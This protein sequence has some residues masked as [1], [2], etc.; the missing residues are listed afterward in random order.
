M[1]KLFTT[2]LG[3][4]L[5]ASGAWAENCYWVHIKPDW[6]ASGLI[7]ADSEAEARAYV[8]EQEPKAVIESVEDLGE[9][10]SAT[11]E[12]EAAFEAEMSGPYADP[13][14]PSTVMESVARGRSPY[15][16]LVKATAT[17][18][19]EKYGGQVVGNLKGV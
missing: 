15:W 10:R 9:S 17:E 13:E 3:A 11:P 14:P 19:V 8:L 7:L 16:R 18:C 4:L 2:T 12:E 5:L 1:K 6:G